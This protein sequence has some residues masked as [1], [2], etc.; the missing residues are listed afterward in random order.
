MKVTVS[1]RV[2]RIH[3]HQCISIQECRKREMSN[4]LRRIYECRRSK[5]LGLLYCN[6]VL[7]NQYKISSQSEFP[8]LDK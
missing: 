6:E 7:Y 1:Y 8:Y 5:H 2:Q 4:E 3:R